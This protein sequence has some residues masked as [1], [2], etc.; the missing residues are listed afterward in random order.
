MFV[1]GVVGGKP[2]IQVGK[3]RAVVV[4]SASFWKA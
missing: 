3:Q 2:T 1:K 4:C